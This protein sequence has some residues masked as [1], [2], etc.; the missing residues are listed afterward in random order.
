MCL[1]MCSAQRYERDIATMQELLARLEQCAGVESCV[2][3]ASTWADEQN[4][5]S[6]SMWEACERS[7]IP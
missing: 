7:C 2:Q 6:H 1:S 5:E 4:A 3:A